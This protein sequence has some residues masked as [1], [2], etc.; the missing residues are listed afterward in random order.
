MSDFRVITG[1]YR[2]C[3]PFALFAFVAIESVFSQ[4]RWEVINRQYRTHDLADVFMLSRTRAVAVGEFGV[5]RLTDDGGETFRYAKSGTVNDLL[6]IGFFDLNTGVIVGRRGS[7]LRTEDGGETWSSVALS[8][9]QDLL[10]VVATAEGNAVAVGSDGGIFV[11]TNDG[12]DWTMKESE[13]SDSLFCVAQGTVGVFIAAG[14]GGTIL[15]SS[16]IGTS[17]SM[18]EAGIDSDV[19][20]VAFGG[21]GWKAGTSTGHLFE[22]SDGTAWDR[23]SGA[24][25]VF[26]YAGLQCFSGDRAARAGY[27]GFEWDAPFQI[28][29]TTDAGETWYIPTGLDVTLG[30]AYA[31]VGPAFHFLSA[32][33]G[34]SVGP[35]GSWKGYDWDLPLDSFVSTRRS[36]YLSVVWTD[37]DCSD[38]MNCLAVGYLQESGGSGYRPIVQSTTDGGETWKEPELPVRSGKNSPPSTPVLRSVRCA[39]PDRGVAVGDSGMFLSID[40][41]DVDRID[42]GLN[43]SRTLFLG[44]LSLHGGSVGAMRSFGDIIVTLDGGKTWTGDSISQYGLAVPYAINSTTWFAM[45]PFYLHHTTNGGETWSLTEKTELGFDENVA[46]GGIDFSDESTGW[47][48][49]SYHGNNVGQRQN[50]VLLKSVDAGAS[51]TVEIDEELVGA[52]FGSVA[53]DFADPRSGLMM[54]T[55]D[56][57]FH[58]VDSGKSW[59]AIPL[60]TA[61]LMVPSFATS[62]LTYPSP[63]IAIAVSKAGEML[64]FSDGISTVDDEP[65]S[66]ESQLLVLSP[67]RPNPAASSASFTIAWNPPIHIDDLTLTVSDL[68][69]REIR[70]LTSRLRASGAGSTTSAIRFNTDSLPEG[71]YLVS[72]SGAGQSATRIL[73]VVR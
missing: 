45:S 69:G 2:I 29:F 54:G 6:S 11:S 38:P 55:R 27:T 5:I 43:L 64:R 63:G 68:T 15:R 71:A 47:I 70:N 26:R 60:P 9:S 56:M 31:S 53:I 73:R 25:T 52:E 36:G 28:Q 58:S 51:W 42:L 49:G 61:E 37:V 35:N 12:V 18:V 17:W 1:L 21:S 32:N 66:T 40:G 41:P 72:L 65:E 16:D 4:G 23:T 7:V 48:V 22:S 24:D 59:S 44:E 19:R 57:A 67:I 46:F 8:T 10:D 62:G 39:G 20:A 30:T 3:L 14:K 33:V 34:T 13:T 50:T